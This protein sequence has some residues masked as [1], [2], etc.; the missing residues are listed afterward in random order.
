MNRISGFLSQVLGGANIE[1]LDKIIVDVV[2]TRGTLLLDEVAELV[3]RV[4]RA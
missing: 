4:P 3:G 2:G 1:A